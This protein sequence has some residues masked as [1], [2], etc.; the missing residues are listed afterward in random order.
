MAN[1]AF[2][3]T[4]DEEISWA[5]ISIILSLYS[6]VT[7]DIIDCEGIKC[8]G[9]IET[10]FSFGTSGGRV[11][12]ETRGKA[13][14]EGSGV[15]SMSAVDRVES[16]LAAIAPERG[17]VKLISV[18]KFSIIIQHKTLSQ[19][20]NIYQTEMLGCRWRSFTL[21]AKEGPDPQF[22]EVDL[23]PTSV[24]KTLKN[25]TRVALL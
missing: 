11:M 19:P 7:I 25:G 15:F 23:G 14:H 10:G 4:D 5:D 22:V 16:A 24:I 9:K 21:D 12:K 18:P 20:N 2:P 6:S 1:E 17:G 13:S 3:V 8:G